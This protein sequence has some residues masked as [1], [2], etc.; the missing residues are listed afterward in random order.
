MVIRGW[1]LSEAALSR[2]APALGASGDVRSQIPTS[3]RATNNASAKRGESGVLIQLLSCVAV[4]AVPLEIR[5]SS[6]SD[7]RA[8]KRNVMVTLLQGFTLADEQ[9]FFTPPLAA[10]LL[11]ISAAFCLGSLALLELY[12]AV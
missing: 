7:Y 2:A 9:P 10:S 6:E 5:S 3:F 4:R 11:A 12:Y 8:S 1:S